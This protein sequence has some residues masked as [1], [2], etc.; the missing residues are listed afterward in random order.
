MSD[1]V[2]PF[3]GT[4][5]LVHSISIGADG[6]TEYPFGEDAIGYIYYSDTGIMAVQIRRRTRGA[7]KDL[8]QLH[9]EY[10]CYFGRYEIDLERSVV[11]HFLEGQLFP[12]A[13]PELLGRRY[14]FV[15]ELVSLKPLDGTSREILWERVAS[16]VL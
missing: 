8:E 13:H 9:H 11:R 14:H 1:T 7:T 15:G 2:N 16:R 10:L 12:G 5:R 6:K 3:V 4:W